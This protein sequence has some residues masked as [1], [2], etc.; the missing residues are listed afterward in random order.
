MENILYFSHYHGPSELYGNSKSNQRLIRIF[1]GPTFED[2][3][4]YLK[5]EKQVELQ[6]QI[7]SSNLCPYR[8]SETLNAMVR[9]QRRYIAGVSL[10]DQI[11]DHAFNEGEFYNYALSLSKGISELHKLGI[12]AQNIKPENVIISQKGTPILVDFGI[13]AITDDMFRVSQSFN[14]IILPCPESISQGYPIWTNETDIF[15]LGILF[16]VMINGSLP[17]NTINLTRIY[18]QL[19]TGKFQYPNETFSKYSPDL[20]ILIQQMTDP[21]PGRRP[22]MDQVV[23]KIQS[24]QE[25]ILESSFLKKSNLQ[26]TKSLKMNP[27]HLET[28]ALGA[29]ARVGN[30]GIRT[31]RR[32]DRESAPILDSIIAEIPPKRSKMGRTKTFSEFEPDPNCY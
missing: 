16:Y 29:I 10:A 3:G 1:E 11:S 13:S 12:V 24:L 4:I 6:S 20:K 22:S 7:Q 32:K 5:I 8:L 30:V 28:L 19:S 17:W 26:H 31:T 23:Q 21:S 14:S 25:G 27:H 2:Q 15:Q 9:I 18:S